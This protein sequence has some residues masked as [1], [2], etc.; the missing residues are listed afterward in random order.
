M[1]LSESFHFFLLKYNINMNGLFIPYSPANP[2]QKELI[3][4]LSKFGVNIRI[5]PETKK[6]SFIRNYKIYSRVQFIHLHWTHSFMVHKDFF[7]TVFNSTRFLLELLFIKIFNIKICWTVHN[8]HNHDKINVVSER[9]F[10]KIIAKFIADKIIVHSESNY[11]DVILHYKLNK[12]SISKISIIPHVSYI[13]AYSNTIDRENARNA[14]N[15]DQ[16]PFVYLFIGLI[17]D[18]KGIKKLITEFNNQEFKNSRLIIAGMIHPKSDE[19]QQ[20]IQTQARSNKNIITYLQYIPDEYLQILLNA[21]DVV[22]LPYENVTTSGSLI[23][24]MSFG[25]AVIIPDFQFASEFV[26]S[27]GA[28]FYDATDV[29]GLKRAMID[30]QVKDYKIMGKINLQTMENN[31]SGLQIA[32]L[33]STLY[34]KFRC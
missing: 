15:L 9:F 4:N 33:T 29:N 5:L 7:I 27:N 31:N 17:R 24:A 13:G 22:V 26:D 23:L 8:I 11:N 18:Y 16:S 10:L 3:K 25:K 12:K 14:I 30:I 2:Y 19:L 1:T 34:E 6:I 21:A 20:F 32:C 28:I